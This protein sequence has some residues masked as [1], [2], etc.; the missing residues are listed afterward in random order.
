MIWYVL[1]AASAVSA[2]AGLSLW[3]VC[4]LVYGANKDEEKR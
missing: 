3:V 2:L 4:S 1:F